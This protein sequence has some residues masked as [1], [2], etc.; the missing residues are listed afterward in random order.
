MSKIPPEDRPSARELAASAG[1]PWECPRCGCK[2]LRGQ[3]SEVE[4][5]R[6]PGQS[7]VRRKRICRHCG[8]G[9]L[10]TQE[11]P[12]P[13]GFRVVVLPVDEAKSAA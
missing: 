2:D 8:Q 11:V 7:F 5:T 3:N 1:G 6:H 9:V 13:S 12:V 10:V 4:S